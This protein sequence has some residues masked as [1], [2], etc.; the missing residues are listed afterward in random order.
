M[1]EFRAILLVTPD[2]LISSDYRKIS[3]VSKIEEESRK[4]FDE[5]GFFG[6]LPLLA[7]EPSEAFFVYFLKQTDCGT[8]IITFTMEVFRI[9]SIP[10]SSIT[11]CS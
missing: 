6:G 7:N 9:P 11:K 8:Q 10:S 1:A 3:L 5:N 4:I 2:S